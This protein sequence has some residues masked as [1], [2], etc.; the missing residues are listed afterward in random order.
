MPITPA[1][2]AKTITVFSSDRLTL[3][4]GGSQ[5][6]ITITEVATA[7][8]YVIVQSTAQGGWISL[9][10][11]KKFDLNDDKVYDL[12]LGITQIM[13]R[14]A[15][16]SYKLISEHVPSPVLQIP[17]SEA[18]EEAAPA[19]P[20]TPT[21]ESAPVAEAVP[22][23]AAEELVV[24]EDKPSNLATILVGVAALVVIA[25]MLFLGLRKKRN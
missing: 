7:S 14:T 6:T 22:E 10:S 21:A 2:D 15:T 8:V 3:T 12:Q 25:V 13:G 16:L 5:H 4:F 20:V 19:V 9:G 1:T 11:S 17:A 24:E 18:A 23:A